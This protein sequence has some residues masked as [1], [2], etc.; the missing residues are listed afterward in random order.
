MEL[1]SDYVVDVQGPRIY[2]DLCHLVRDSAA[3]V[4][5]RDLIVTTLLNHVFFLPQDH[6]DW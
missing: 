3:V 5:L 1:V 6:T 2:T 4:E